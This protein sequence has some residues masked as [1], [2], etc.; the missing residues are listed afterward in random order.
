MRIFSLTIAL[1]L[2]IFFLACSGNPEN[3][4]ERT[5]PAVY[6][7][8]E[9][10][11]LALLMREMYDDMYRVRESIKAGE[12]AEIS[13]DAEAL[14]T[15]E[16]TDEDQVSSDRY[17]AMGQSFIALVNAFQN[18]TSANIESHYSVVVESCMSCHQYS[19]PGP[20]RR[21]QNLYL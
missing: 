4:T 1:V 10:S 14:F 5:S 6:S 15:A 21:I 2:L 12:T 19:C 3:A 9:D 16:P 8:N 11:E 7:P 20:M 18:A 17:R 13:F